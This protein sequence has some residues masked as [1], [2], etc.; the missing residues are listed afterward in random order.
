[1]TGV[2]WRERFAGW[3]AAPPVTDF[4]RALMGG[5][6]HR[7]SM[8]VDAYVD[9][10]DAWIRN[11][12][13]AGRVDGGTL[14]CDLLA[15]GTAEVRAGTFRLFVPANGELSDALH[16]RM[17]Y[18]LSL[19]D[20]AAGPLTLHGFKLIENDPGFDAWRDTTTLFTRVYR[21]A[22]VPED[23]DERLLL[24]TGVLRIDLPSF[25]RQLISFTGTGGRLARRVRAVTLYQ[26]WFAR[27][28]ARTYVGAP[29]TLTRPSFPVDRPEPD[30]E[31]PRRER[32]WHP[33]AGNGRLERQVVPF[34]VEDLDF[35]INVQRLRLADG[36]G[37]RGEPDGPPVLLIPGSGVRANMFYGQPAGET[38]AEC[39]LRHGYDVWVENWRASIDFPT[40]R[41][42]LDQAA[43]IDHPRAVE[44]VLDRTGHRD[45][46][47]RA[48]AHCQG[49]VS[50]LMAYVAGYLDGK[51]SHVVSSAV[52]LF[53]EVRWPTWLK[54]RA[55]VPIVQLAMPW[56]DA[57]WGLRSDT[58]TGSVFGAIAKVIERP[59]GNPPCQVASF[60]YGSGWDTLLLHTDSQGRDWLHPAVHDWSARELG[61]TPMSFIDQICE[62]SRY[63]HIVPAQPRGPFWPAN[64]L[65]RPK[66]LLPAAARPRF[67]FIAGDQN[68]M[69]RWQG[70]R[71]AARFMREVHGCPA[72]FVGLPGFG[73][74]DTIWGRQAA[75]VVFPVI[76]DGLQWDGDIPAPGELAQ[77]RG[78]DRTLNEAWPDRRGTLAT[79]TGSA[80]RRPVRR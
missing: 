16:L 12:H 40:N 33:V 50:F 58:P 53:I 22:D 21:G 56:M 64:Y 43:R 7:G 18:A 55:A 20:A 41:Y 25:A 32:D 37:S 52:S 4:N 69:F 76:L 26:W 2:R 80:R 36:N 46:Q 78:E 15:G 17:R 9:D 60:M 31:I 70:Q 48:V 68:R 75:N 38:L 6:R 42:T 45:G 30:W 39:L 54:Q 62:S 77:A 24:A 72:E 23:A 35:A 14:R 65:A 74:L 63:G 57:Q 61:A 44:V 73:H 79:A 49:S 11:P 19:H 51:V 28:L 27:R 67:T 71:K 5:A 8:S 66:A 34:D 10:V 1:M 47:L 13:Y 59:C 29:I 3:L